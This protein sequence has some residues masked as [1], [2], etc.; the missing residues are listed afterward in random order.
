LRKVSLTVNKDIL[1]DDSYSYYIKLLCEVS[2]EIK[3][4]FPF[5]YSEYAFE[6]FSNEFEAL[7]HIET[8]LSK[9]YQILGDIKFNYK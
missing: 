8:N 7:T 5:S 9:E 4:V 2:G 1:P 3:L 6:G